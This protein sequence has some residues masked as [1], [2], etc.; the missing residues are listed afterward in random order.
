MELVVKKRDGR[1]EDFDAEKIMRGL[2]KAVKLNGVNERKI[3]VIMQNILQKIRD[4]HSQKLSTEDVGQI[5][6]EE[7]KKTD[8]MAYLRF[9]SICKKFHAAHEFEQEV[10]NLEQIEG[11]GHESISLSN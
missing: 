4:H 2:Q 9:A 1:E 3:E 6:M 10:R 8:P 11:V 7:L 5:V